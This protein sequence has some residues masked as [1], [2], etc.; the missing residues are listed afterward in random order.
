MKKTSEETAKDLFDSAIEECANS[1]FSTTQAED[2]QTQQFTA[3][4]NEL[5]QTGDMSNFSPPSQPQAIDARQ[6]P[7]GRL[8]AE[9]GEGR[10]ELLPRDPVDDRTS[11]P[12]EDDILFLGCLKNVR[13]SDKFNEYSLGR[14]SK[15]DIQPLRPSK[16]ACSDDTFQIHRW[17]HSMIS[18]RHC[19]LFCMLKPG[20]GMD[21]FVEDSSGNG[22]VVNGT[23]LLKKGEKRLLHTGDEICLVNPIPLRKK[24][25]N[26]EFI[27]SV[28]RRYTFVFVNVFQ[29]HECYFSTGKRKRKNMITPSS[30]KR[31]GIVDVRAMLC[32][33]FEQPAPDDIASGKM[34]NCLDQ[35]EQEST[36]VKRRV[37]QFYDVRDILGTGTCGEVK[38][39]ISRKT[40]KEFAVKTIQLAGRNRGTNMTEQASAA[41]RAEASILQ[42]LDH[43]Y[44]VKLHDVFVDPGVAINIVMEL[45]SGG[46]L[47]D[48]IV[49]KGRYTEVECR[50]AM[51]R[52]LNAIYYLHE[53]KSLVHRDLKPENI[54]CVSTENDVNLK[55]TDFGLAKNVTS[56]GLKTFCG[57]PQYFAPEVLR[58]N[59]TIAGKGRYGKEADMWSLGV[60]LYI[61]LSGT[62]PFDLGEGFEV[63]A[64]G[65]INF[66]DAQWKGISS[67]AKDLV[68]QLL[69]IDARDRLSVKDTCEH[70]WILME[71]GDSHTHPLDNP[72]ARM[73]EPANRN[74]PNKKL[75]DANENTV[76]SSK[77]S[78]LESETKVVSEKRQTTPTKHVEAGQVTPPEQLAYPRRDINSRSN[79]FR[80]VIARSAE[81]EEQRL[82][83]VLKSEKVGHPDFCSSPV[84]RQAETVRAR[85]LSAENKIIRV[86]EQKKSIAS[87]PHSRAKDLSDDEI[88]SQ[89]SAVESS[90]SM[91][92]NTI[93]IK[94]DSDA[95][96][97]E[98]LSRNGSCASSFSDGVKGQRPNH[99]EK[100]NHSPC[101]V[102]DDII[103]HKVR[104]K[105]KITTIESGKDRDRSKTANK[106]PGHS[107]SKQTK[108]S[109]WLRKNVT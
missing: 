1:Q 25:G 58:R 85:N 79:N 55:L 54:L 24:I 33:S 93:A 61:L 98:V 56:E 43:P 32:K 44:I 22:T 102:Q 38:R 104:T 97:A 83:E 23:T 59:Y 29:Q 40:G 72:E 78:I 90:H 30:N 21:V 103:I 45:V 27:T 100:E 69:K 87:L 14:N 60:I 82:R 36:E 37:E 62:P 68:K 65:K 66:P 4:D 109:S 50:R 19:N 94:S 108:L 12:S 41:L 106:N 13:S 63:V 31:R 48:R 42:T 16:R 75:V 76:S 92:S 10:Y 91:D 11:T 5:T 71:D 26:K 74:S 53:K 46:D 96:K 20:G 99:D 35:V 8:I 51:R 49:K 73:R 15:M 3:M 47:F 81:K 28:Q 57:T 52:L 18:N 2:S 101:T 84:V 77:E 89:F 9:E 105:T 17:A 86:G 67:A 39:A 7:W 80:E 70:S 95:E 107:H 34:V 88:C 64:D 6:V